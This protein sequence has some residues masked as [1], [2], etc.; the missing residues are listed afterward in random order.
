[1]GSLR[2]ECHIASGVP[3]TSVAFGVLGTCLVSGILS[4]TWP[5][6][7]KKSS[8]K[9]MSWDMGSREEVKLGLLGHNT[10]SEVLADG[11]QCLTWGP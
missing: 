1:M 6:V 2:F 3:S 8:N 9:V 7:E 10:F 4:T 11:R 5:P